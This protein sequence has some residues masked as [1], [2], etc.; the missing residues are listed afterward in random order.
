MLGFLAVIAIV[1]V[2]A[3]LLQ[4]QVKN[5]TQYTQVEIDMDEQSKVLFEKRL[6]VAK[7]GLEARKRAGQEDLRLTEAVASDAY[8]LGR[9]TEAKEIYEE[10]LQ[11]NPINPVVWTAYASILEEM[12]EL[13]SAEEAYYQALSVNATSA[14]F[15]RYIRFTKRH[16]ADERHQEIRAMYELALQTLGDETWILNGLAEWYAKDG[17]CE[18]E[19]EHYEKALQVATNKESAQKNLDDAR[20]SCGM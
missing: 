20:E 3:I 18:Q 15:D 1:I 2:T 17:N 16:Y 6:A 12:N 10:Y 7:A 11:L 9:L 13:E 8:F 5:E 4:S 14:N 19:V